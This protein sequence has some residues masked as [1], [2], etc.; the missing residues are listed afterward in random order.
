MADCIGIWTMNYSRPGN[1][2]STKFRQVQLLKILKSIITCGR[3][4]YGM[5][6]LTLALWKTTDSWHST[7]QDHMSCIADHG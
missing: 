7:L 2:T 3:Q 1:E 6:K 5:L 4:S